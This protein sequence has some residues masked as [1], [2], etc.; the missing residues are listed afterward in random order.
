MAG[1]VRAIPVALAGVH[2]AT[3]VTQRAHSGGGSTAAYAR[4]PTARQVSSGVKVLAEVGSGLR[5]GVWMTSVQS[6]DVRD[7][8]GQVVFA[9]ESE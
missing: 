3:R 8:G 7:L 5:S 4:A 2:R 9:A 1:P 6:Y